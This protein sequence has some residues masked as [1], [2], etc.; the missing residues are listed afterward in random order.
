M[1]KGNNLEPS[2]GAIGM[3]LNNAKTIFMKTKNIIAL[4]NNSGILKG[5]I[6]ENLKKIEPRMAKKIFEAG[7]AIAIN[8]ISV[9]GSE[10]FRILTGTGFAHPNPRKYNANVPIGS[11]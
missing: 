1:N 10:R 7:P 8:I 2:K 4:V 11:K 6:V 5:A 3:R 9:L